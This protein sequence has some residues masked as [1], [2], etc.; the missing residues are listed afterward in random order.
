MDELGKYKVKFETT[1]LNVG[2]FAWIARY[3]LNALKYTF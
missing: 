3:A 2:D 1:K